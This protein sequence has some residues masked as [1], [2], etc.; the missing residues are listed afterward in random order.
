MSQ[1]HA[2][3][4]TISASSDDLSSLRRPSA[5]IVA[6]SPKTRKLLFLGDFV[7]RGF[8]S[9]EVALYVFALKVLAPDNVHLL[10]GNHELQVLSV[11]LG[12]L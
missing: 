9:L 4:D 1:L 12:L 8:A 3:E 5:E 11:T 7:D 2:L 6:A 10:R